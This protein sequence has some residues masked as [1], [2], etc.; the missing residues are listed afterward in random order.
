MENSMPFTA[1]LVMLSPVLLYFLINA[2][3]ILTSVALLCLVRK[4]SH[5]QI[6]RSQNDVIATIFNKAGALVG[7]MIAFVVVIL[8]QEYNK[9]RDNA[10]KEGTEAL[11]LYRDLILY[12]D[13]EQAAGAIKSLGQF[14]KLVVEDEYPAMAD[15]RMSQATEQE[16]S[17]LR[18]K[19]HH[20]CPQK[21]R[22]QILYNKILKDFET[23]SKLRQN[24]L[25]ETESS[26][27]GI[28]WVVL[29]AGAIII[30]LFSIFLGTEKL[31][32][33]L[34]MTS[35]LAIVLANAFYLILELDYPFM[36]ELC[37]KPTS[38]I[39]MLKIIEVK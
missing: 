32:L 34:L 4:C 8:W 20:M 10:L 12:P 21:S 27:P 31:W 7:I 26:L 29:I 39:E 3:F 5:Y 17:T 30:I 38:Y 11:E 23:L 1:K 37:V 6:R 2:V 14:A 19:I 16:L 18:K 35:M 28:V 22:D 15:M 33:H 25:L 36:G 9:S 24:R 13:Q